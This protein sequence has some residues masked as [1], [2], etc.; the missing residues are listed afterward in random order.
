MYSH[1]F[2]S[3]VVSGT[4]TLPVMAIMAAVCWM[5]PDLSSWPL[6]AGLCIAGLTTYVAMELNNRFALLRIRSRMVSSTYLLLL[7]ACPTLHSS[8]LTALPVALCLALSYAMLFASYQQMKAQGYVF[9]AF[10]CIG[11]GS[12]LFPPM[13]GLALTFYL[14]MIV[15]LRN[16][17]WRSFTAG[18]LGLALPYWIY[19]VWAIWNNRLDTAF[20]YL[21]AWFAP[22][23]PDFSTFG[24]HEWVT[25]GMLCFFTLLALVHFF[26]TAYNDKIR[27]RMLFY[28][29]VTQ[30]LAITAG[31]FLLPEHLDCML[32]LFVFNASLLL[33]HYYA[34]AKGRFFDSWFNLSLAA[35]V[36]LALYNNLNF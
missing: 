29:V 28:V 32:S 12:L 26:H 14:N 22:H 17:T 36:V 21:T 13:L 20:V 31:L 15:Q 11:M 18:L 16:F 19:A 4:F 6:W 34:L 5:L 8:V 9:H 33:A 7:T 35:W 30:Q 25:V 24:P 3:K 27:T 1:S 2:R 10:L 23:V